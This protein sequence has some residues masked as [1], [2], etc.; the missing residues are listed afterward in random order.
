M[1]TLAGIFASS[2]LIGVLLF[3]GAGRLNWML[4]WLFLLVWLLLKVV[5]ILLLRWHDPNLLVER[6]TRHENTQRYDR[7]IVPVY[8]VLSFAT[9]L[10]AG[11]DGGRFHWSGELPIGLIIAAYIVYLLGNGLAS[12]AVSANPFF[13]SESR[14]QVERNQEVTRLGPYRFVRHPAYLATIIIWPVTGLCL[15]SWYAAI[16]GLLAA[17]M[18]FIRTVYEDRMLH[19]ELSGYTDYTQQVRYRL[20]PGIW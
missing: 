9:I 1:K 20:F 4:G 5:F 6:A 18:M 3:V 12:W 19:T 10:V 11:L 17:L 8:F 2:I 16:P 14:L 7:L 15:E 13:S